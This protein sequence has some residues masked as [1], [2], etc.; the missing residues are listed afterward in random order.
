MPSLPSCFFYQADCL[1]LPYNLLYYLLGGL[2]YLLASYLSELM[3]PAVDSFK[4]IQTSTAFSLASFFL[5][6]AM[7]PLMYA[8]ETLSEKRMKEMELKSYLEKAKKVK[9]KYA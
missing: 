6:L 5:F 2:P 7:L 3:K 9:E 1:I 4:V 8:P